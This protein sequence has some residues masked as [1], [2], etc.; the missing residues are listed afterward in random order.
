MKSID[1]EYRYGRYEQI[2][3]KWTWKIW[4]I[5]GDKEYMDTYGR[6]GIYDRYGIYGQIWKFYIDME[7]MDIYGMCDRYGKYGYIWIDM[8]YM[9]RWIDMED[10]EQGSR[11]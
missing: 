2:Q 11:H 9:D 7:C 3:N 6:Y 5:C 4:N 10:L 8:K 1:L